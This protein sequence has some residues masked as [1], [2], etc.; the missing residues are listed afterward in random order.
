MDWISKSGCKEWH[1][2]LYTNISGKSYGYPLSGYWYGAYQE[3]ISISCS[4]IIHLVCDFEFAWAFICAYNF[5][6]SAVC[7]NV[8]PNTINLLSL[9][10]AYHLLNTRKKLL[11]SMWSK[12]IIRLE[13]YDNGKMSERFS[14]SEAD[15][16]I[17]R[18]TG[19]EHFTCLLY[20]NSS[21]H[22]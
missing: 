11:L 21:E 19:H 8:A 4:H 14:I 7:D 12:I 15:K 5:H 3:S 22:F 10:F 16:L 9:I 6:S 17:Y 18:W 13:C 20:T 2:K 1:N